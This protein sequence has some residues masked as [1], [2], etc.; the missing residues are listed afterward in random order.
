MSCQLHIPAPLP[1]EKEPPGPIPS[2]GKDEQ[3]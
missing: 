1:K 2:L 3:K